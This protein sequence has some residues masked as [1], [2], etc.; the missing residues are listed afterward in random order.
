MYT[1]KL[2]GTFLDKPSLT[3]EG[4]S[5]PYKTL[6]AQYWPSETYTNPDGKVETFPEICS[7]TFTLSSQIGNLKSDT[8]YR[9]MASKNGQLT[10]EELPEETKKTL[11]SFVRSQKN[12]NKQISQMASEDYGV[13]VEFTNA[14]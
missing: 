6:S 11:L 3:L 8:V 13:F 2:E 7:L 14:K 9:V 5:I 10:F 12:V 1:F 4:I